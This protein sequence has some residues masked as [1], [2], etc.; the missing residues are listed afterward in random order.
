MIDNIKFIKM[1][2]ERKY[3]G[4]ELASIFNVSRTAVWKKIKKLEKEGYQIQIDKGGYSILSV[5]DKLL[6]QEIYPLLNTRFIG[7]NYIH[8]DEINSTNDYIK[9]RE[10]PDGTVVVAEKQTAGKGRKGRIWLSLYAKGLYFS[11]LLKPHIE[12]HLLSKLN[13]VFLY[14]VFKSL[15]RYLEKQSLKIK[16]PNDIY[17][18]GKKVA[19]F[20]IDTAIE[21][22]EIRKVILG[23]GINVNNE[24]EDFQDLN[25]ATSLR[26]ET[27]KNFDRKQILVSILESIERE[28][29]NFLQTKYF[30]IKNIEEN[31]LWLGESVKVMDD[32][33]VIFEGIIEGLNDDGALKLRHK[34]ERKLIYIGELSVRKI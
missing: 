8:F 16:W 3:S 20:L 15:E 12:V 4:E 29:Y 23:I 5:P 17:L 32:Y 30:D 22:N 9:S 7:H 34:N 6:S 14:A 27:K 31:L 13:L 25:M 33:D 24:I 26:I 18:N 19:G 2:K 1:L 28:Y 21:N 10:F 11:I